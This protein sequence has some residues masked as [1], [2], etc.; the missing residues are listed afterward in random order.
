MDF[1]VLLAAAGILATVVASW[2]DLRSRVNRM[3]EMIG[4]GK[5]GVFVRAEVLKEMKET[6]DEEH[7]EFRRRLGALEKP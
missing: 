6:A 1:S 4:N 3:Q 2:A 7:E 5:P